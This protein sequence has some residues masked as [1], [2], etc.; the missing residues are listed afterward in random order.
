MEKRLN[1]VDSKDLERAIT[2]LVDYMNTSGHN[3]KPVILHSI[4]TGMK[5]L[6]YG[7]RKEL[8][9]AGLLHDVLEDSDAKESD[10]NSLFGEE[11][12]KLV[13]ALTFKEEIR[14]DVNKYINAV[15]QKINAGKDA[16]IIDTADRFTNLPYIVLA[17]NNELFYWLIKK[18]EL[19]IKMEKDLLKYEAIYKDLKKE[20]NKV[21]KQELLKPGSF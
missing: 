21:K 3:P 9:I 10:I 16:C 5:L 20:F 4:L 6:G 11:V 8:V 19:S 12:T 2:F 18:A 17:Q 14:Y 1:P 13:K 7:Y 15:K